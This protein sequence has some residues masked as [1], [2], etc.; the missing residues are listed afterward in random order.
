MSGKHRWRGIFRQAIKP[1]SPV[2]VGQ[3]YENLTGSQTM[4]FEEL[5][6]LRQASPQA[7]A[8]VAPKT[9]AYSFSAACGCLNLTG[10]QLLQM[11]SAEMIDFYV[12]IHGLKGCWHRD[13][14]DGRPIGASVQIPTAGYL[15]LTYRACRTL[16]NFG[17]V[18]VSS[19][20]YRYPSTPDAINLDVET[21]AMLAVAGNCDKYFCLQKPLWVDREK[22]VI[23][24]PLLSVT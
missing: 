12:A 20:E 22:L 24:D 16:A 10:E 1:K 6:L 14:A 2:Q 19:L 21:V 18:N 11:A 13:A 4:R 5:V 7:T 3:K 9:K 15:A 8:S 17:G 23:L